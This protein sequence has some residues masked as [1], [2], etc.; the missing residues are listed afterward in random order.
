[1]RA[2]DAALFDTGLVAGLEMGKAAAFSFIGAVI[3]LYLV[4]KSSELAGLHIRI[5]MD[6][7]CALTVPV[8]PG[9]ARCALFLAA[10]RP[11]QGTNLAFAFADETSGC[12]I[13]RALG[14]VLP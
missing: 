4:R 13:D 8:V 5:E 7:E 12:G 11:K 14:G 1:M 6:I 10:R 3:A 9:L 2:P